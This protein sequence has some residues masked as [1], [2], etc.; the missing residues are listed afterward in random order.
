MTGIPSAEDAVPTLFPVQVCFVVSDVPTAVEQCRARFRWGPFRQ[1]TARVEGVG[2]RRVTEVALG[3]AGRVQ[4]ELIHAHEG[5]GVVESYQERY[6]RGL[7][8]LGIVCRS[9][10]AALAR[11]EALGGKRAELGE[12]EG[13]RIGFTDVPT[14]PAMFE[15]LEPTGAAEI[16]TGEAGALALDRATIATLDMKGA[17]RF[18]AAAFGWGDVRAETQT[19]RYGDATTAVERFV[20]RA[21]ALELELLAPRPGGDDPYAAHLARGDHGLV[22]AGGPAPAE[23]P[24]GASI[25]C[26]WVEAREPFALHDWAGG[27]R[28]LQVRRPPG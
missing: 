6:G 18:Y 20:G 21:G 7:Q 27:E 4:V 19:L 9:R 10:A 28:A 8:H 12:Y 26:E 14:G 15:L 25:E 3:M 2:G 1:F 13:V 24:D 11:L 17:L 16:Q 5:H 23:P 22:H